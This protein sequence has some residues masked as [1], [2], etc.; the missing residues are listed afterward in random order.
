MT[1][2]KTEFLVTSS[3]RI[4]SQNLNPPPK[5]NIS[6]VKITLHGNF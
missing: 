1:L 2:Q 5:K 3:M 4:V 6:E